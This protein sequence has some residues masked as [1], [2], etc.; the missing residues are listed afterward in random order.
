MQI[1][2]SSRQGDIL[3][4]DDLPENLRVLSD[5][6]IRQGHRVRAVRNGAMAL[7]GARTAPPDVILLDIRMPEMDGYE[8]CQQL[9]ADPV[10]QAIP[11]IFLSALDE[12]IDKARAF[13][14]GGVDYIT[15][16][17]QVQEV[18][19][20]VQHQLTIQALQKQVVAQQQQL[21]A[22]EGEALNL[23]YFAVKEQATGNVVSAI[24]TILSYTDR[25]SQN[26]T[27]TSANYTRLLEIQRHSQDLLNLISTLGEE[28]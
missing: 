9:K 19:A 17:F 28:S 16:P 13:A 2:A 21:Q 23:P 4:V 12:T 3:I 20:R 22:S 24:A 1:D 14:V 25:L 15:K 7:I 10:T 5:T 6:L 11:V 18:L 26:P 8:V 27:L